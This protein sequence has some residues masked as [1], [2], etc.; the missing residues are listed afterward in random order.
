MTHRHT[1]GNKV[2]R[3]GICREKSERCAIWGYESFGI[4]L[5]YRQA[6]CPSS[7][8]SIFNFILM[9]SAACFCRA[10]SRNDDHFSPTHSSPLHSILRWKQKFLLSS[11]FVSDERNVLIL[12]SELFV[13]KGGVVTYFSS[14]NAVV[15]SDRYIVTRR[16]PNCK[17]QIREPK[18]K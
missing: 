13:A 8:K 15:L 5:H 16:R 2:L 3:S 12:P 14:T 10:R 9:T 6:L 1:L 4:N 17:G 11:F 18:Q 7:T